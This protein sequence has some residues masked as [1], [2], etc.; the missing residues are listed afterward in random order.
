MVNAL[1]SSRAG[2]TK[3]FEVN[4]VHFGW[5]EIQV[6]ILMRAYYGLCTHVLTV[7]F[8]MYCTENVC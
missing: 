7:E 3:D 4:G 1:F 8:S 6:I 2:G 5:K